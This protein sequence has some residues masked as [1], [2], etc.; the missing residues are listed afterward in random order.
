MFFDESLILQQLRY[1][2]ML[3]TVRIRRS[4][5][6]AKYTFQVRCWIWDSLMPADELQRLLRQQALL[7]IQ[8]T[9]LLLG[10]LHSDRNCNST[11]LTVDMLMFQEF[12]EHFRVLLPRNAACQEDISALMQKMGLDNTTYQIGKTKV[13]ETAP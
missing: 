1:T 6:G 9:A 11:K 7:W 13:I 12:L 3:E 8:I 4:G 10:D 2:G 5:Y